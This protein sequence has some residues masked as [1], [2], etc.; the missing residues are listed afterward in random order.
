MSLRPSQR[1]SKVKT[2]DDTERLCAFVPV[3]GERRQC[4]V[5]AGKTAGTSAPVLAVL[6]TTTPWQLKKKKKAI[7]LKKVLH[8]VVKIINFIKF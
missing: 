3:L 4:K 1:V 7:S 8:D 2:N 6:V 5:T